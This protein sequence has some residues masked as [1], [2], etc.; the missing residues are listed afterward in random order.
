MIENHEVWPDLHDGS[1]FCA[2]KGDKPEGRKKKNNDMGT[3]I[4]EMLSNQ[5]PSL[6][7]SV[8]SCAYNHDIMPSKRSL[9]D[10]WDIIPCILIKAPEW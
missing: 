9:F 3:C 7:C 8:M 2:P 6:G 10:L 4:L 1:F 5:P